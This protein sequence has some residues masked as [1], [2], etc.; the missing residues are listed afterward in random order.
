MQDKLQELTERLYSEGVAKAKQ[1]AER[2]LA[3][4]KQKAEVIIKDAK[5]DAEALKTAAKR[6]IEEERRNVES[7]V[8]MAARQAE[9]T[10]KDRI[11]RLITASLVDGQ[12]AAAMSDVDFMKQLITELV[13]GAGKDIGALRLELPASSEAKLKDYLK[14]GALAKLSAGLD[15]RFDQTLSGGFRVG[16]KDKGFVVSFTD[17]GF[18]EFFREYLRPRARRYLYGDVG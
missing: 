6:S 17:E 7:E 18:A 4:A 11:A 13:S 3:E 1:E 2:I 15:V 9:S 14:T 5:A 10:L 8:K 12:S 16:P